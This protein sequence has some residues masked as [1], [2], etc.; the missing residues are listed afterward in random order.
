M[1][2]AVKILGGGV[3]LRLG[4]SS[5]ILQRERREQLQRELEALD[6]EILNC[7]HRKAEV[8]GILHELEEAEQAL[9]RM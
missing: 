7:V 9:R 8:A 6:G 3:T 2:Q 5:N 4:D 1:R